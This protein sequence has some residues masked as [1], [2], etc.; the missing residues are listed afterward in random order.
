MK[1]IHADPKKIRDIFNER[2][3]VPDYQRPY[4]WEIDHCK[5]LWDDFLNFLN[6]DPSSEDKYFLGNI[7]IYKEHESYVV[8]DGQQRLTTLVLLIKALFDHAGTYEVLAKC[9]KTSDPLTSRLKDEL[10][11]ES[12]VIASDK[13]NLNDLVLKGPESTPEC[14]IKENFLFFKNEI[15]EWRKNSG[16]DSAK[17][18]NLILKLL[19]SVVILPIH[20]DS[21][22]DALIIFETINNRGLPLTDSDIFKAKLYN[23]SGK[24][25]D[26]IKRWNK[27]S[28]HEQYFR[29]LMH[30]GRAKEKNSGR[31][32]ALRNYFT[33][34]Q[35]RRLSNWKGILD[36]LNILDAIGQ[37]EPNDEVVSLWEIMETYP[38]Q[39]WKFPLYVFLFKHGKLSN[40]LFHLDNE[41]LVDFELL[42]NMTV[43][44]FFIKGF[45]HNS[46]SS[47]R[48]T[49]FK[50][51]VSIEENK[52]YLKDYADN[53]DEKDKHTFEREIFG[54]ISGRYFD[55]LV[56]LTAY[57]N[58]RQN[59]KKFRK[60]ITSSKHHKEHILPKNWN[61][62]DGGW[63]ED[64]WKTAKDTLGNVIPLEEKLNISAR[65]E[66][67]DRKKQKYEGSLIQDAIDLLSNQRWTP[68]EWEANEKI[69]GDRILDYL[70]SKS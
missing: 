33:E 38:N 62:Y 43:K 21:E 1:A 66:F 30:A 47:V 8:I 68:I 41:R 26:V 24:N 9:I 13:E 39:Y 3:I 70:F 56:L 51:Y 45:V 42:L 57:L 28:N 22:D 27:L 25:E 6:K 67:F 49:S 61:N 52:D 19:D 40:G 17:F 31:E 54:D 5:Q 44:Y 58:P 16:N 11:I 34:E 59:K 69:R 4:S 2:Y 23:F 48:D 15:A 14:K 36:Q 10:K 35:N 46:V 37:W 20:C 65:N 32:I 53:L 63:T 18:E 29:V 55:G 7:V 60:Y 64:N 12:K 50:V